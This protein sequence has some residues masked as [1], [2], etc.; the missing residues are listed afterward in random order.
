M[1]S[2]GS[3]LVTITGSIGFAVVVAILQVVQPEYDA[4]NQLMSELALGPHGWAMLFAFFSLG[5]AVAGAAMTVRMYAG[6][7]CGTHWVLAV[8]SAAFFGA[9]VFPLGATSELHIALVAV[10]FVAVALSTYL[11]PR[12]ASNA[13]RPRLRP[14]WILGGALALSVTFGESLFP[15]GVAQRVSAGFLIMWLVWLSFAAR[16]GAQQLA[17]PDAG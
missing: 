14:S 12:S 16:G 13:D 10:A 8:A 11:L 3:E 5:A 9:G 6:G 2:T 4:A 17:A 1:T 7:S 15:I